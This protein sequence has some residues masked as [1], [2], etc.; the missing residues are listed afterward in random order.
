MRGLACL[1]GAAVIPILCISHSK[2]Q[3]GLSLNFSAKD[4]ERLAKF[5]VNHRSLGATSRIHSTVWE[6]SCE[7]KV[8]ISRRDNNKFLCFKFLFISEKEMLLHLRQFQL[9][10]RLE[11]H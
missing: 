8:L 1:S 2:K 4:E 10:F 5:I 7:F 11:E 9:E 3:P 6:G